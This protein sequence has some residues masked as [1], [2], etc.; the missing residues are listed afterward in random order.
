MWPRKSAERRRQ[1]RKRQRIPA[2]LPRE[3]P[4]VCK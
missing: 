4:H 2:H 3:I 1:S